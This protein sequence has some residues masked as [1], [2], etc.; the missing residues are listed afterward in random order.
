MILSEY[1]ERLVDASPVRFYVS[2]ND[3]ARSWWPWRMNKAGSDEFRPAFVD[4]CDHHLLDSNFKDES[5][6]NRE[7]LDEAH[8]HGCDGAVLADVYLDGEA[9]VDALLTGLEVYDDHA[10]DGLVVLPLQEPYAESYREVEPAVGGREVWWALGGLKDEAPPVKIGKSRAFRDAVGY[11]PHVHGLGY[12]VSERMARAIRKW[13]RMLDSIDNSRSYYDTRKRDA[14]MP[15]ASGTEIMTVQ[16][17]RMTAERVRALREMTH[18]A[19]DPDDPAQVR[20]KG[21]SGL[22]DEWLAADGGAR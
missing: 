5:V 18:F 8:E 10:F 22:N 6:G 13:P 12:G 11:E 9:T 1:F 2:E 21:Q 4:A 7:V 15:A 14:W 16:A 17:A 19:A 3:G 20:A